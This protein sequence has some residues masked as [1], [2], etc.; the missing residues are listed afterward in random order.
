MKLLDT[1]DKRLLDTGRDLDGRELARQIGR[2][3][4][5]AISGGR[6]VRWGPSTVALPVD[7]GYSVLITLEAGDDYTVRRIFKRGRKTWVKGELRGVYCDEVG[8]AAYRA[9]CFRNG[10]WMEVAA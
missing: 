4:V 9:S 1:T 6:L 3:N 10:P 8:E 5:L 2:M 7:N